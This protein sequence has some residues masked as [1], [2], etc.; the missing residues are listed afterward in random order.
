[1]K[2][3]LVTFAGILFGLYIVFSLLDY[4]G[5]Y[6]VE[7]KMW[8]ANQKYAQVVKDPQSVPDRT[9]EDLARQYQ[10]IID[11]HPDS[12]LAP[13]AHMIMTSLYLVKKDYAVAREKAQEVFKKYP[14]NTEICAE[15]MSA[16]GKSYELA[17]D[18]P[19][20]LKAYRELINKYP[21]TEVGM[22]APVYIA[23]YYA[24]NNMPS[25]AQSAFNEAILHFKD[26]EAA[27]AGTEIE[28]NSLR[29]QANSYLF[30]K[31]WA[32]GIDAYG[33]ILIRSATL[34]RLTPQ[35]G[36]FLIKTINT[37]PGTQL[38]DYDTPI[39]IYKKFMAEN[40]KHKLN[41]IMEGMI[42]TFEAMKSKKMEVSTPK[43]K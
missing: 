23:N 33:K 41:Q 29:L 40:P 27:H 16:I 28:L 32:E 1:M 18:W 39:R 38:K 19:N 11:Q 24:K 4:K 14:Q 20:A 37:L 3:S 31:K 42:K 7:Q 15:A 26:L 30:Q 21:M 12:T 6:A 9:Y 5:E 13:K 25:Q 22:N 2:R 10:K 36:L 43:E 8:A 35:Q 17:R 34:N